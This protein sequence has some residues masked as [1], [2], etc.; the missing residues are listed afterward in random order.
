SDQRQQHALSAS[1]RGLVLPAR[2]RASDAAVTT[3]KAETLYIQYRRFS[4]SCS[5]KSHPAR[6]I[7]SR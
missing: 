3:F 5:T 4:I 6:N 7:L 2:L 1:S